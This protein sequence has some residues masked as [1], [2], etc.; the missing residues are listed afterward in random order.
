MFKFD[1]SRGV[2]THII[3]ATLRVDNEP[4]NKLA[5][6][7]YAILDICNHFKGC[8]TPRIISSPRHHDLSSSLDT[9]NYTLD[10][11]LMK[12]TLLVQQTS[13]LEMDWYWLI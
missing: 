5:P 4:S 6:S 7:I 8:V 10:K 1:I 3:Y 9:L 11:S 12:F 2:P 13:Y